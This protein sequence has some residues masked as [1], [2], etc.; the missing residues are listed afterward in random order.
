MK[1]NKTSGLL[2][3]MVAIV[4]AA[5][6]KDN[7]NFLYNDAALSITV[8]GYN[9]TKEELAVKI[10][11]IHLPGTL[12]AEGAFELRNSF[13][14]KGDQQ[15]V[16]VTVSEQSTGKLILEKEFKK[17]AD[18][19]DVSFLY[20]NGKVSDMPEKP[21]VKEEKISLIYMF[22]PDV[23]HYSEPVDIVIGK[24]FV[25]PRVF[26][27]VSRIKGV[28]PNEFSQPATF[29]TFPTGKQEYNGV[30]T[31]VSFQVRIF[32]AGTNTPY[33]DGTAYT[34]NDISTTAPKPAST[35]AVSKLYIFSEFPSGNLMR[36]STRL[37]Y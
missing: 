28:K 5:C 16:K 25:T 7:N 12:R 15:A 21:A 19:G 34:W 10:D 1:I 14:F 13:A 36:F 6:N 24:Y 9:A 27:E 23:T 37:D 20:M 4:L 29:S 22:I 18:A 11:T 35:T 32:K 30:V 8:K 31:S 33:V 3:G 2:M 26:E 17:E